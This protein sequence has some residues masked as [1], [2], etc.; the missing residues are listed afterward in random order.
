MVIPAPAEE[1]VRAVQNTTNAQFRP[2]FGDGPSRSTVVPM[3]ILAFLIWGRKQ[4]VASTRRCNS[5]LAPSP[6][7]GPRKPVPGPDAD[8]LAQLTACPRD[9]L[10]DAPV[11]ARPGS[12]TPA[13]WLSEMPAHHGTRTTGHSRPD[14]PAPPSPPGHPSTRPRP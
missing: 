9:G 11:A 13:I 8:A 6:R 4:G 14:P 5:P 1:T 12:R 7:E 2:S 3:L 10:P